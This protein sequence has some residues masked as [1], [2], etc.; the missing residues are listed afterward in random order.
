MDFAST[1]RPLGVDDCPNQPSRFLYR[2]FRTVL[3]KARHALSHWTTEASRIPD[4]ELRQQALASLRDKRFHADGGCVFAAAADNAQA[5]QIVEVI[6][7][8]QTISDYLDNLCDRMNVLDERDF[9]QLHHAMRDAVRPNAPHQDYYALHPNTQDGGYLDALVDTCQVQLASMRRYPLIA[10]HVE[11]FVERYCEL[12]QIKHID[13][14]NRHARLEAWAAAYGQEFPDIEWWEFAA[15]TGS[16]LGMFALITAS[17]TTQSDLAEDGRQIVQGYF[18]WICGLHILL[19]YVIDVEED[20]RE[21]DFNFILCYTSEKT[22]VD[23]LRVFASKSLTAAKHLG[24][25]SAIHQHVVLGLIGM[26]LS[27]EK[28]RRQPIA[29]AARR[30]VWSFGPTAWLYYAASVVYRVV[31]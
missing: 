23:R 3:P 21:G 16:T 2:L 12:Q 27:D 20:R 17:L 5:E 4:T 22:A 18:P 1:A 11:W 13:P 29:R 30:L 25:H 8:L 7:A 6:V 31:R 9:R 14:Q 24:R 15:A 28:A 10:P 26:Y 19:D